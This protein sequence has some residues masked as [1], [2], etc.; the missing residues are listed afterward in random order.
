MVFGKD[1]SM[2]IEMVGNIVYSTVN[3]YY[4][5]MDKSRFMSH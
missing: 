2:M 5:V 1:E 4:Y 3:I